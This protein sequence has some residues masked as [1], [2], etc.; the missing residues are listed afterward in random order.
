MCKLLSTSGDQSIELQ[1]GNPLVVGRPVT[2][3]VPIDDPTLARRH[4]EIALPD[5]GVKVTD[6]GSANGTFP[7]GARVAEAVAAMNDVVTFGKV[8][9]RV[10]ETADPTPRP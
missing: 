9:C 7:N 2:S 3:D 6:L 4:A 5:G 10:V 8:A 1:P